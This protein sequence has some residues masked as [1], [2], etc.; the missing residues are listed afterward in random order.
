MSVGLV[1]DDLIVLQRCLAT[2][3]PL[4]AARPGSSEASVRLRRALAGYDSARLRYS[5][6][7]TFEDKTQASLWGVDCCGVSGLI[8]AN[9]ARYWPL[10]LIT[11]RVLQL[12]GPR[13]KEPS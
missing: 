10:V 13:N 8:R 3:L 2:E 6:K 11:V 12:I 1:I 7:K 5:D 9:P 4:F